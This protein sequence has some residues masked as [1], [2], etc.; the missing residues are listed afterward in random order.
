VLSCSGS[1]VTRAQ[2][3][4]AWAAWVDVA[5][6]SDG[7][8]IKTARLDGEFR[9]G[10]TIVSKPIGFPAVTALGISWTI[11]FVE[12]PRLWVSESHGPG[13][14]MIAEH[15]IEAGAA[16]TRLTEQLSF[17]GPLGAL[18]GRTVRRRLE[19]TLASMTEQI[20]REAERRGSA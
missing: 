20:A 5:G 3:E 15:L 18:L 11:T 8:V 17:G 13:A 1:A 6:W 19:A 12:P 14:R 10:S 4:D 2:P 9:E 16:G 7:D